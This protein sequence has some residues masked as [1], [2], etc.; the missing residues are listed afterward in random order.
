[1][2]SL[3]SFIE[4]NKGISIIFNVIEKKQNKITPFML[5]RKILTNNILETTMTNIQ[6]TLCR[7]D[8]E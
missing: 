2:L 7:Y 6:Q 8:P 3:A 5:V 1:M 4:L